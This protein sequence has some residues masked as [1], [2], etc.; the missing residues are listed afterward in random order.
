MGW[1]DRPAI[2]GGRTGDALSADEIADAERRDAT[3]LPEP[4]P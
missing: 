4:T 2:R 3:P 1:F